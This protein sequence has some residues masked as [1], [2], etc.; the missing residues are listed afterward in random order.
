[1]QYLCVARYSSTLRRPRRTARRT[2]FFVEHAEDL[3]SRI[4]RYFFAYWPSPS[5]KGE[6]AIP[7]AEG[8]SDFDEAITPERLQALTRV[9]ASVSRIICHLTSSEGVRKAWDRLCDGK[10]PHKKRNENRRDF[11][12][13][14]DPGSSRDQSGIDSGS[15]QDRFGETRKSGK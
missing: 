3:Q 1:M 2:S 14:I 13:A 10:R 7:V 15:I 4:S 6:W 5:R 9:H 8:G 11:Q 12:S